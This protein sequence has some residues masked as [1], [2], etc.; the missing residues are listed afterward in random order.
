[1]RVCILSMQSFRLE[2]FDA[3]TDLAD[4]TV[5]VEMPVGNYFHVEVEPTCGLA[6][7][8][9]ALDVL[10]DIRSFYSPLH[11]KA[12]LLWFQQGFVEYRFPNVSNPLL[13]LSE[14]MFQMEICSEAPGFLEDWPS[15]ITISI[16]GIE[17][18]TYC[19][20][21]DFGAR[22]GHLT[23]R[24]W[25]NGRTQYGMLKSFS[26]SEKGG[27]LDGKLVNPQICLDDLRVG[28]FPYISLKIEIKKDAAHIGGINLFGEKYGD[29][30]VGIVMNLVY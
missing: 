5:T 11:T 23:P 10:D 17:V 1:M 3:E 8:N 12:Q 28:D 30:P 15:D 29:F 21:G 9:G 27:F 6:D 25:P 19:S 26:V 13:K 22:R 24:A 4:N 7:E 16:N 18:T 14:I 2:T 20:P